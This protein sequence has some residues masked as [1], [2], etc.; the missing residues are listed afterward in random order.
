MDIT[1][2]TVAKQAVNVE[3]GSNTFPIDISGLAGGTYNIYAIG[4]DKRTKVSRFVKQ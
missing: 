2:R 1:G 3:T 4:P